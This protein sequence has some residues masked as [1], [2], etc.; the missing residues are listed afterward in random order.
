MTELAGFSGAAVPS[1]DLAR[2]R[3]LSRELSTALAEFHEATSR[4]PG[5][6]GARALSRLVRGE[7]RPQDE[8]LLA[9]PVEQ[10]RLLWVSVPSGRHAERLVD[11]VGADGRVVALIHGETEVLLLV[12]DLPSRD[13]SS[14]SKEA[15]ER[16][17]R[18]A[19]ALVTTAT[20]GISSPLQTLHDLPSAVDEARG[21]A[22]FGQ[23]FTFADDHWARLGVTGLADQLSRCLTISNPLSVLARN[24]MLSE[25][26]AAWLD[27]GRNV[28]AAAEALGLHP[29]TLRYR[30]NRVHEVTGLDLTDPDALLLAQLLLRSRSSS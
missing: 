28:P 24:E 12:P 14:R 7:G 1:R 27:H 17:A 30:L 15:A 8:V 4:E 18:Q 5:S 19:R 16:V 25:S 13:G 23:G 20:I 3:S 11:E 21:V 10:S 9:V 2:L 6:P 26:V 22:G 29:N